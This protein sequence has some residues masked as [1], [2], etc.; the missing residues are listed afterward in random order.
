[1]GNGALCPF[2]VHQ[3]KVPPRTLS[4]NPDAAIASLGVEAWHFP[5]LSPGTYYLWQLPGSDHEMGKWVS[6]KMIRRISLPLQATADS[7]PSHSTHTASHGTARR[8]RRAALV[9][10]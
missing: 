4:R 9:A 6:G 2:G 8:A 10:M 1:M 7:R 5:F 3:A